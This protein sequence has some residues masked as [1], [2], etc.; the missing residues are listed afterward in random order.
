MQ[1]SQC[2]LCARRQDRHWLPILHSCWLK[3]TR[4]WPFMLF[5]FCKWHPSH[6]KDHHH[7]SQLHP[8]R[9][10]CWMKEEEIIKEVPLPIW[11]RHKPHRSLPTNCFNW[12]TVQH[13]KPLGCYFCWDNL[14]GPRLDCRTSLNQII[15]VHPSWSKHTPHLCFWLLFSMV[16]AF[17]IFVFILFFIW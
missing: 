9:P 14:E 13:V 8:T 12:I 10:G 4:R 7:Q 1:Q 16:V 3:R 5:F 6:N 17:F 2:R 11:A 15:L